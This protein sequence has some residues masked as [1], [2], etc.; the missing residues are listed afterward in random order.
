MFSAELA[1]I[2]GRELDASAST[3]QAIRSA[4]ENAFIQNESIAN[5]VAG[6]FYLDRGSRRSAT[7][8][9]RTRAAVI[10]GGELRAR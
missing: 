9:C 10:S 4:R 7:P 3:K 1:R 6:R 5:E 2:E 8:A